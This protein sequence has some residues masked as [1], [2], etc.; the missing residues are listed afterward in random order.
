MGSEGGTR[1]GPQSGSW[2][3][4]DDAREARST[5]CIDYSASTIGL[6]DYPCAAVFRYGGGM[7]TTSRRL[8]FWTPR[9]LCLLF[10]AFVSLFALDV[11][12][13]HLGFWKT[14]LAFAIHLTPTWIVL[15]VLTVTWRW[16]WVGA[17]LFN[18]L[19]V[20][21]V[22]M[23]WGRFNWSVYALISGPLCIVGLLFLLNW[24]YRAEI[25]SAA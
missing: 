15:G 7:K 19:A 14:V 1:F 25:R 16:E 5:S 9:I 23:A 6:F 20:L 21:Y 3:C 11:F 2:L 4:K 12:D 17:I 13:E 8:L 24:R 18:L 22:V 10:A